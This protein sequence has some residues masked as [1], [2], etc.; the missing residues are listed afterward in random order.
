MRQ[1]A[2]SVVVL[3]L[4]GLGVG[5]GR[6]WAGDPA[7]EDVVGT[8]RGRGAWKGCTV[9]GNAKVVI[10]VGWKDG[11]Y[12]VALAGARDDLGAVSLLPQG[13]GTAIGSRDDLKVVMKAGAPARITLASEGGCT[14]TLTISRDTT[15]IA[16]CDALL[17]LA[18]VESTCAAAGDSRGAHLDDA[19]GKAAGW[20][21][22]RGKAKKAA[23]DQCAADG[24]TLA[25]ALDGNGC[26]PRTFAIGAGGTGVA[27]CDAYVAGMQRFMMC[28]NLPIETKQAMQQTTAQM[29]E[30]FKMMRDPGLPAEARQVAADACK[31]GLE[32]VRQSAAAMG[33]QI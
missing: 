4:A 27:A 22:L 13:D 1:A 12:Q 21:K 19:R 25:G 23:A 9:A 33:C 31:Q 3:V 17:A 20:K 30:S 7:V 29:I 32:A 5:V 10:D 16:G 24:A 18:A 6:A 26:L 14:G 15:G 8:W 11:A 28:K 2:G